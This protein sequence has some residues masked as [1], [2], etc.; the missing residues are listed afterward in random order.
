MGAVVSVARRVPP[1]NNQ[2]HCAVQAGR[3][4]KAAIAEVKK[5][6]TDPVTGEQFEPAADFQRYHQLVARHAQLFGP[7]AE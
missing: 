2:C 5:I 4:V 7:A 1:P 3:V 6:Y